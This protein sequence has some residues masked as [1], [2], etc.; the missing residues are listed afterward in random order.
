V[1]LLL[2]AIVASL[3]AACATP[4]QVTLDTGGLKYVSGGI[5]I[6]FKNPL[7]R[8]FIDGK[9]RIDSWDYAPPIVFDSSDGSRVSLPAEFFRKEGRP[10]EGTLRV[11]MNN[12]GSVEDYSAFFTDLELRNSETDGQIWVLMRELP[13]HRDKVKLDVLIDDYTE[14]LSFEEYTR[15]G[16][17][18]VWLLPTK[19]YA[20]RIVSKKPTM[21]GPFEAVIATIEIANLAQLQLD[22][23]SRMGFVR[24]LMARVPG[25]TTNVID[26]AEGYLPRSHVGL[27]VVGYYDSTA[28]FEKGASDF[29]AFLKQFTVNGKPVTVECAEL[30]A[31]PA[32]QPP[33]PTVAPVSTPSTESIP[34]TLSTP[35]TGSP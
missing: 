31:A 15:T 27:L 22:P 21:F 34:S 2:I 25:F 29:E 7:K 13:A 28:Y 9:W 32:P 4:S 1:R 5:G 17:F 6:E 23:Q 19:K 26:Y 12:D 3:A 10:F 14:R 16:P 8:E 24:V 33:A 35:P 20:A 11:D 30:S 18:D